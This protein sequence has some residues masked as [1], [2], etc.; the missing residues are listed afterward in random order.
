MFFT[1][2]K[3]N[4]TKT[5]TVLLPNRSLKALNELAATH[6]LAELTHD[7][8]YGVVYY[9]VNS[10]DVHFNHLCVFCF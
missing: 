10:R 7:D 4:S 3:R 9:V 8:I 1:L 2:S 5:V 6:S